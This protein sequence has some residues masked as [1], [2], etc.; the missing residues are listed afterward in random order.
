MIDVGLIG[1]GLQGRLVHAAGDSCCSGFQLSREL[2]RRSGKKQASLYPRA[3][4][5]AVR[6]RNC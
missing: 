1:F 5:V 3:R 2:C 6:L 4:I